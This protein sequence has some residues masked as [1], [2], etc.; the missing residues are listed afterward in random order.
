MKKKVHEDLSTIENFKATI[1]DAS[2]RLQ[3]INDTLQELKAGPLT[4]DNLPMLMADTEGYIKDRIL[5][6]QDLS[7]LQGLNLDRKALA[8]MMQLPDL[9]ELHNNIYQY[10]KALKNV[11]HLDLSNFLTIGKAVT[12]NTAAVEAHCDNF[13][14]FAET[15]DQQQA[16]DKY[17]K[18]ISAMNVLNDHLQN[19]GNSGLHMINPNTYYQWDGTKITLNPGFLQSIL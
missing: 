14:V 17:L 6:Q 10:Q 11:P 4:F 2:K 7:S 9:T 13:R 18:L 19:K 5:D 8:G 12:I 15:T 1:Q 3:L 16:A